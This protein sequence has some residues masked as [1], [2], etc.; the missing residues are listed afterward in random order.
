[1]VVICKEKFSD[2]FY[3]FRIRKCIFRYYTQ[4]SNNILQQTFV[5]FT[6]QIMNQIKI[7][8]SSIIDQDI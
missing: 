5:T 6:L 2:L 7:L 8:E 3:N 1:M 4:T